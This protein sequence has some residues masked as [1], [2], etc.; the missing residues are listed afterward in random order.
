MS[1]DYIVGFQS[2]PGYGVAKHPNEMTIEDFK[3]AVGRS[4]DSDMSNGPKLVN[5]VVGVHNGDYF[6]ILKKFENKLSDSENRLK[7][8]ENKVDQL[9][10]TNEKPKK[11]F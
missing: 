3:Q 4:W 2:T 10:N 6:K 8:L 9:L 5:T 1:G 7:N 11:G